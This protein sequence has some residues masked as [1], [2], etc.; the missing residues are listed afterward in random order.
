MIN[1]LTE[2]IC[3]LVRENKSDCDT[4]WCPIGNVNIFLVLMIV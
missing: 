4:L 2:N 3:M 1:G